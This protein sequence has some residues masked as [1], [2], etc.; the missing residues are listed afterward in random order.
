[1]DL[2]VRAFRT[3]HAA[4]AETQPP[5][6]HKEAPRKGGSVGE[7]S[8]ARPVWPDGLKPGCVSGNL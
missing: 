4:I 3:V 6:K 1:M 2:N 7:Q 8:R 5:D